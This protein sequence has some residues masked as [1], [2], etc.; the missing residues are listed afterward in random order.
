MRYGVKGQVLKS[1]GLDVRGYG[2]SD[3]GVRVFGMGIGIGVSVFGF[4]FLGSGRT[5]SFSREVPQCKRCSA[6]SALDASSP[7]R[8]PPKLRC[9]RLGSVRSGP[10][11][12]IANSLLLHFHSSLPVYLNLSLP[13]YFD[14]SS[15]RL[16]SYATR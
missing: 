3:L 15:L 16:G 8:Y 5:V 12:D 7:C 13:I 14:S 9:M 1:S 10:A 2:V 4:R 11:R 6:G